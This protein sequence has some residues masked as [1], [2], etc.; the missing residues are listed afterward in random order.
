MLFNKEIGQKLLSH[1]CGFADWLAWY[2][3]TNSS[4]PW[5]TFALLICII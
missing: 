4:R 3:I 1:S 5:E 2:E